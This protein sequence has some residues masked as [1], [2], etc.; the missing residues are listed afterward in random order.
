MAKI[1]GKRTTPAVKQSADCI[2][3]NYIIRGAQN[4]AKRWRSI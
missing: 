4:F 3:E 2:T 1:K